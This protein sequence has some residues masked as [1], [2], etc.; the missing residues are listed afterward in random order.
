MQ[1]IIQHFSHATIIAA[2][3]LLGIT[4][5]NKP[6][7]K[8][9][10]TL[11]E[12]EQ[13]TVYV[14]AEGGSCSVSYILEGAVEGVSPQATPDDADWL[15]DFSTDEYGVITFEA[16]A[17]PGETEREAAVNVA[18]ADIVTGF[19][20]I[21]AGAGDDPDNPDEP[22]E[23]PF[24]IE[25]KEVGATNVIAAITA[26]DQDMTYF[27]NGAG[28]QDIN[29]Y[30]DDETFV[31]DYLFRYF[32]LV[33]EQNQ[34]SVADVLDL[35][36]LK[37]DQ[38]NQE[39]IGLSAETDYYV[40]CV[41]LNNQLEVLS[42][43]VKEPFTTEPYAP[44]DTEIDVSVQ[45]PVATVTTT[46][47]DDETGYYTTVVEGHGLSEDE[48][49]SAAESA[50]MTAAMQLYMW[51]MS[52]DQAITSCTQQGKDTLTFDTLKENTAYTACAFSVD[53]AGSVT[54]S[55]AKV[56]FTTEE[57]LESDNVITVTFDQISSRR[58]DFTVTPSVEEAYVFFSY[59]LT[60]ELKAMSDDE[61]IAKICSEKY[62]PNWI[63]YSAVSSYEDNLHPDTEYIIYAFGYSG[64]KATTGL[65]KYPYR[66][67]TV[68]YNDR[69]F[70]YN[71]GPYFHGS[72]VYEKYPELGDF[73]GK[74]IMPATAQVAGGNFWQVY[75]I[76]YK[77][78][79]TDESRYTEEIMYYGIMDDNPYTSYN[80]S[81][82]YSATFG[83]VYTLF[84]FVETEDGNFSELYRQ[85]VGPFTEDGCSP[86]DEFSPY[87]APAHNVCPPATFDGNMSI[88]SEYTIIEP[89]TA[90]DPENIL[91][92]DHAPV[93]LLPVTMED[94]S[95]VN[96]AVFVK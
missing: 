30:P 15:R 39:I 14:S 16:D 42:E 84:G 65:F 26:K 22:E 59:Q 44:F 47:A 96:P 19:T 61:I 76:M 94:G 60:D 70:T 62:M 34:L 50:L 91:S 33:A 24:T 37:G 69:V 90:P 66:T 31:N 78:D 36:L 43:F 29:T 2:A 55:A 75:H 88:G 87:G 10:T 35:M 11:F 67:K 63:R 58:A 74:A 83:E 49:A 77:G 23:V 72:E 25:I 92:G 1:K 53:V 4:S 80:M 68:E 6:D 64:Q 71:Y 20:V 3:L 81:V 48:M 17:N 28:A 86:I 82:L 79:L 38:D 56:E 27:F 51:G 7:D 32:E 13:D 40:F 93:Y 18:Y 95:R 5:C 46:P 85:L 89:L 57:A 52:I 21:Q 9:Q 12:L 73:S 54:S 41:G 8:T 45:G